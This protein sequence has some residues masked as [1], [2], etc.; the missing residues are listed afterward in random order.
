METQARR[1]DLDNFSFDEFVSFLFEPDMQPASEDEDPWHWN[2]ESEIVA[3]RVCAYY[4]NIS[5]ATVSA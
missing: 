2:M 4:V 3:R 5:Q 1:G